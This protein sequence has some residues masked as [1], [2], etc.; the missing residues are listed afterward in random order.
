MVSFKDAPEDIR[1][2]LGIEK[3]GPGSGR[4]A[5]GGSKTSEGFHAAG[6]KAATDKYNYRRAILFQDHRTAMTGA[7]QAY[8]ETAGRSAAHFDT[9]K[10]EFEGKMKEQ[11]TPD[12]QKEVQSRYEGGR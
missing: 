1:N 8:G 7:K 11:F 12:K 2:S 5:E 9:Q 6:M 4:H 3:G 10:P